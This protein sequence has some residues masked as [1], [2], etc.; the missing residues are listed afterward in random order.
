MILD[1]SNMVMAV[2]PNIVDSGSL[3]LS[4]NPLPQNKPIHLC[5]IRG[6]DSN[7]T[8]DMPKYRL[9]RG[10]VPNLENAIKN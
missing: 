2:V 9:Q 4:F 8:Y 5:L 7:N 3:T 1:L 10:E 6:K